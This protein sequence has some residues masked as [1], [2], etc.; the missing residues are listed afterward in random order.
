[1]KV[2]CRR[3][4]LLP[5]IQLVSAAVPIRDAKSVLR[6]VKATFHADRCT[7]QATDLELGL[8]LEIDGTAVKEPGD[9]LLPA[10]QTLAIMRETTDEELAFETE[11]NACHVRG[12]ASEFELC[13]EDPAHFPDVP[14]FTADKYHEIRAGTLRELIRRTLFAVAS[15]ANRFALT[16]VLWELDGDIARLVGSDGRRLAIA[17]GI[18]KPHGDHK[19]NAQNQIVPAKAMQLLERNLRGGDEV[20]CVNLSANEAIFKTEHTTIYTRLVEGRFPRYREIMPKKATTKISLVAGPLLTALRQAAIMADSGDRK[21]A[22]QFSKQ[23][24]TL[25]ASGAESGHSKVELPID[26]VGK[27]AQIAFD[28]KM[29][30]DML[31]ALPGDAALVLEMAD[32]K[33]PAAFRCGDNFTYVVVPLV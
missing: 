4:I 25:Q 26:F 3:D 7:L 32:D 15:D 28:P 31:N 13:T 33:T 30:T 20:V 23:K 8:R 17:Q 19:A 16:G 29:L 1:M 14:I 22:L 2:V 10:A 24:L 9:V 11:S 18:A 6:N 21:V 27:S 5:S 12:G